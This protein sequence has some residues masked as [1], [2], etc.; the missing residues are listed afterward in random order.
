MTYIIFLILVIKEG[1]GERRKSPGTKGR[2]LPNSCLT[3][4]II[5]IIQKNTEVNCGLRMQRWMLL[6]P[7]LAK[8]R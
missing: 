8:M 4:P 5:S 3:S 1:Q 6:M 2:N 7:I